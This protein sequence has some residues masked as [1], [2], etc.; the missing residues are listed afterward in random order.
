MGLKERLAKLDQRVLSSRF[1]GGLVRPRRSDEAVEQHLRYL[2][3][4]GGFGSNLLA[5]DV[6]VVL[7]RVAALEDRVSQLER[8]L[9]SVEGHEI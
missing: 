6:L 5:E 8:R 4:V 2:A 7:N 9:A 1:R 3:E